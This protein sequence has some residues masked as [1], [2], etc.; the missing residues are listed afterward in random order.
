VK[1][2][3]ETH[4][5]EIVGGYDPG[6]DGPEPRWGRVAVKCAR[7]G[8]ERRVGCSPADLALQSGC[9]RRGP[10]QPWQRGDLL[11]RDGYLDEFVRLSPEDGKAVTWNGTWEFSDPALLRP[12]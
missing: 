1:N 12:Y 6:Q 11:V 5:F 9:V 10:D 8:E 7:C 3:R 2:R 4:Q